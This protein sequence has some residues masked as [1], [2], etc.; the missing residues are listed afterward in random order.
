MKLI[1]GFEDFNVMIFN[2]Q[3]WHNCNKNCSY[4]TAR[5]DMPKQSV[6]S[7]NHYTMVALKLAKIQKKFDRTITV[8]I[9][10]GEPI[11]NPYIFNILD[12]LDNDKIYINIFT[13]MT[14]TL[15]IYTKLLKRYKK[16]TIQSSIHMESYSEKEYK[17]IKIL[18]EQF[19]KRVY[20]SMLVH[21]DKSYIEPM[22]K[23]LQKLKK[24]NIHY[25]YS[26]LMDDHCDYI[27]EDEYTYSY[28]DEFPLTDLKTI[29]I[30][31]KSDLRNLYMN[32]TY[33]YNSTETNFK[34]KLCRSYL[35]DI[36]ND[37]VING[38]SGKI[39]HILTFNPSTECQRCIKPICG[40]SSL[41]LMYPKYKD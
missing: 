3:F 22:K 39:G 14:G 18:N 7:E 26:Y 36:G 24:D 27:L 37:N 10:G 9:E 4:C 29:V 32:M 5:F 6:K 25:I 40:H 23:V 20:A 34:D 28:R 30:E 2:W 17:K 35:Y 33:N 15:E 13:N 11:L 41:E 31:D 1:A 19:P 16:L 21:T 12:I 8:E 38:C